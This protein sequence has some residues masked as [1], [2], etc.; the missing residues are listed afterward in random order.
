[1]CES[2]PRIK[3]RTKI[4]DDFD[5][6]HSLQAVRLWIQPIIVYSWIILLVLRECL[7]RYSNHNVMFWLWHLCNIQANV[8]ITS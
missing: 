7:T 6:L 8:E 2:I 1:L 5:F 3:V 4:H